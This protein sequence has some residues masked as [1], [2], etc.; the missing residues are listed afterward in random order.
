MLALLVD[1]REDLLTQALRD[2]AAGAPGIELRATCIDLAAPEAATLLETAVQ[3]AISDGIRTRDLG[4]TASTAAATAAII[5]RLAHRTGD[6]GV[7]DQ[8][9]RQ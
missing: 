5:E 7:S 2:V 4:G 3:S 9:R 8:R 1:V 6:C